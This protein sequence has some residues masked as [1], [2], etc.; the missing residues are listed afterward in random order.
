[1]FEKIL[2]PTKTYDT[3]PTQSIVLEKRTSNESVP[4]IVPESIISETETVQDILETNEDPFENE[5]ISTE[6]VLLENCRVSPVEN[7]LET[8]ASKPMESNGIP[9]NTPTYEDI[10]HSSEESSSSSSEDETAAVPEVGLPDEDQ[11]L[12]KEDQLKTSEDDE[13]NNFE[14]KLESLFK[15][16][17]LKAKV[18]EKPKIQKN[19]SES[20]I[21]QNEHLNKRRATRPKVRRPIRKRQ[22]RNGRLL[23]VL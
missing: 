14:K 8:V 17:S 20:I 15:S 1:M 13:K 23:M 5:I 11:K 21:R 19:N 9:I 3:S 16:N 2:T 6:N 12:I 18:F 22:N 7:L 4:S 10:F